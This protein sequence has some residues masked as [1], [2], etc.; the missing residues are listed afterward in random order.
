MVDE[1]R[2]TTR[3]EAPGVSEQVACR[4]HGRDF[5]VRELSVLRALIAGPERLNR[6]ALSKEFC[7]RIG[8]YKPDGGLKDM[9]ARVTMLAMHRDGL[10]ELPPPS[11]KPTPPGPIV[12]GPET[13]PPLFPAATRLDDLQP[14]QVR[15][16]VRGT[17]DSALWNR[18]RAFMTCV[19]ASLFVR[20]KARSRPTGA[21]SAATCWRCQPISAI[22]APPIR[23][24]ILR[25]GL[26]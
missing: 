13:E 25:T 2:E 5:T 16:V 20:S 12:F 14:L 24:V 6:H 3:S 15:T 9:M 10:I 23:T 18:G 7:R 17:R 4:Y 19:T 11:W 1:R 21:M 26:Q 8:W 22:P